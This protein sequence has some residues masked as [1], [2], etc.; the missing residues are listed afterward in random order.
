MF[1]VYFD[2]L[3]C[4][5]ASICE[6]ES[7]GVRRLHGV[8]KPEQ[9]ERFLIWQTHNHP[10]PHTTYSLR[11]RSLPKPDLFE[12]HTQYIPPQ[13]VAKHCPWSV[14][15]PSHLMVCEH[16]ISRSKW[17]CTILQQLSP[18]GSPM[19]YHVPIFSL[20]NN[21]DWTWSL[22]NV[23]P[24]LPQPRFTAKRLRHWIWGGNKANT[25]G[26]SR[27]GWASGTTLNKKFDPL[28]DPIFL[29]GKLFLLGPGNGR[30]YISVGRRIIP[31]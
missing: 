16:P 8:E 4:S 21:G 30:V 6:F 26:F 12:F 13:H 7:R 27:R 3:V 29:G 1:I 15:I 23:S 9:P 14:N 5:L 17:G 10:F 22:Q 28:F 19:V 24:R 25:E 18:Y 2:K 11:F 20:P 31:E